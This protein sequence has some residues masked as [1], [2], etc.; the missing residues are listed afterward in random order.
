[1]ED[2]KGNIWFG[3]RIG[4]AS[5]Y[6]G[7]S[8]TNSTSRDG[9]SI[10]NDEVCAIYEDSKGN[11]WLSSEGYG[12]YRYDGKVFSNFDKTEGLG[13]SAVQTIHEDNKGRIWV[14]GGGGLY[15]IESA[16]FQNITKQGPWD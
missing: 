1:M 4:G 9:K 11:I 16:T 8:F 6:D 5:T 14:G 3:T 15:R 13:V 10:E 7:T 12:V 2:S